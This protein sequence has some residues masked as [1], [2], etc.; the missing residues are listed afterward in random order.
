MPRAIEESLLYNYLR[1]VQTLKTVLD[2]SVD[3]LQKVKQ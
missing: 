2:I 3:P 1:L